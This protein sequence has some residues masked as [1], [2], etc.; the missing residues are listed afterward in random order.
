MK[1]IYAATRLLRRGNTRVHMFRRVEQGA[2][3]DPIV[4]CHSC[5][6]N[7]QRCA[8]RNRNGYEPFQRELP[9]HRDSRKR[10]IVFLY[11]LV[12]SNVNSL[13]SLLATPN[14]DP[15]GRAIGTTGKNQQSA[16]ENSYLSA[17]ADLLARRKGANK[18]ADPRQGTAFQKQSKH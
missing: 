10:S 16:P 18:C 12:D 8:H 14:P 11:S 17:S 3:R 4:C 1:V 2:F 15:S 9:L 5:A 13:K 6:L 7:G